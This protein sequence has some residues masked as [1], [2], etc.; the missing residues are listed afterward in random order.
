[1]SDDNECPLK[2]E[3]GCKIGGAICQSPLNCDLRKKKE[4][5]K[6][7]EKEKTEKTIKM[8]SDPEPPSEDD[9]I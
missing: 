6:E 8:N 4:K 5:K 3:G 1:M 9:K 2:E 7:K